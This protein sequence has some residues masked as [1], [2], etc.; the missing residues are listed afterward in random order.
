MHN[1][2]YSQLN[3]EFFEH[4][5]NYRRSDNDRYDVL[6]LNPSEIYGQL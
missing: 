4:K 6:I 3:R 1:S 2:A 5:K